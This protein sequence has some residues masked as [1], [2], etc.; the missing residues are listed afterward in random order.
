[1]QLNIRQAYLAMYHLLDKMCDEYP[2]ECLIHLVSNFSPYIFL[3]SMSADPAAWWDWGNVVSKI[4]SEEFLTPADALRATIEF[5]RFH[6][7]EFGFEVGWLVDKLNA[8]PVDSKE[9]LDAV[10]KALTEQ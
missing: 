1:M 8:L 2:D 4:A 5:M 7:N 10:N 3:N 6:H 9:W